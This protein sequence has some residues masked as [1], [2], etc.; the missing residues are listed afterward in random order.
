MPQRTVV[1]PPFALAG[2]RDTDIYRHLC[3]SS[4]VPTSIEGAK[5]ELTAENLIRVCG[6][7][8]EVERF[9]R[10]TRVGRSIEVSRW[11]FQFVGS[12]VW[13][14]QYWGTKLCVDPG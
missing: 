8:L 10:L 14:R 13:G 11:E 9:E 2:R 4:A 3:S 6:K 7:V 5:S 1:V 12:D